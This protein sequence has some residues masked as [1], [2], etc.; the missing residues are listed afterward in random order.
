MEFIFFTVLFIWIIFLQQKLNKLSDTIDMIAKTN[1]KVPQI[2]KNHTETLPKKQENILQEKIHTENVEKVLTENT[3]KVLTKNVEKIHTENVDFK[4][5]EDDS[6]ISKIFLGNIFNKIG[7]IAI[8]IAVIIFI[9][10]VSPY[11][12]ITPLFK[13]FAG[14]IA[15]FIMI[16]IA[17]HLRKNEKLQNYSEVLLGTGFADLF[18]TTFC[19][20]GMFH[21]LNTWSV[22]IIGAIL[23]ISTYIISDKMKTNSMLK[24]GLIGGYL[25]P[26][27]SGTDTNISISY[28]IFLNAISAA[29]SL[30]NKNVKAIN[31]VNL[32]LTMIIMSFIKTSNEICIALP[33][34]LWLVYIIY[35][36]LREKDLNDY[37]TG[38]SLINYGVLTVFTI[39][40]YQEI[41]SLLEV[42][43]I[44]TALGYVGLSTYSR[45]INFEQFK[46]YDYYILLNVWFLIFFIQGD[47]YKIFAWSASAL[48]L[49]LVCKKFNFEHLQKFIIGYHYSAFSLTLLAHTD[50]QFCLTAQYNPI[51]NIR[52]AIFSIPAISMFITSYIVEK[53]K[54]I[55]RFTAVALAYIFV[56][57][58]INSFAS[59]IV[60]Y[61]LI[62]FNKTMT[63]III[64]F[65]YSLQNRIMFNKTNFK[66]Y[67]LAE[68][69]AFLIAL[70][71][72]IIN[73]YSY[74]EGF[75]NILNFR[76]AAY[77]AAIICSIV[78]SKKY[79]LFKYISVFLGF[80]LCYSE[81]ASLYD[82]Y[83]VQFQYLISIVLI[84]YSALITIA[85]IFKNLDYLKHSGIILSIFTI[86]RIFIYDLATVDAL[87]KLI[88]LL[89]LGVIL[90]FVSYLYSKKKF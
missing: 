48:I 30:K 59:T 12:V 31:I 25:T 5:S 67:S 46:N 6:D 80:M 17:F 49:S 88:I 69:T 21:I 52:A 19:G 79:D 70:I 2:Q 73:S 36:L 34:I 43:F 22:I 86:I 78:K 10:L 4:K 75:M 35:D 64:G 63:Y 82:I 85:G 38:V 66:V 87:Y 77:I 16:G 32:I 58:E 3:E 13:I 45:K 62:E 84:L 50:R 76:F 26:F 39:L 1:R 83:G 89:I 57:A 27:M 18:I 56:I 37:D 15:G 33:L 54:D 42:V 40:I 74:P 81:S 44:C 14:F 23:L 9:K 24:I 61:E 47:L 11:I 7:A 51:I 68:Y 8:I 65:V 53:Y 71:A 60:Q 29:Y 90:M 41:R 72:L 20:Y 28:L 55:L